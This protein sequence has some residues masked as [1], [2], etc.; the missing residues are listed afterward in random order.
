MFSNSKAGTI[1]AESVEK[2]IDLYLY[3]GMVIRQKSSR[4]ENFVA[5]II[6]ALSIL[7]SMLWFHQIY[8]TLSSSL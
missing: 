5:L 7:D 4:R 6:P 8:V 1:T 3:V 2:V